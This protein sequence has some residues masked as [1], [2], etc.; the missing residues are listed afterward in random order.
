M[1]SR[2]SL[3]K[4]APQGFVLKP[5]QQPLPALSAVAGPACHTAAHSSRLGTVKQASCQKEPASSTPPG[6][7]AF[8]HKKQQ[9]RSSWPTQL[10]ICPTPL[11]YLAIKYI[12][13]ELLAALPACRT[14]ELSSKRSK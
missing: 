2:S 10:S 4:H 8:H 13:P 7:L 14:A 12:P 5:N 9:Q 3:P 1:S 6:L 11:P